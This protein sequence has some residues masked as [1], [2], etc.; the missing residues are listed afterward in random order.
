[1]GTRISNMAP[2]HL[3]SITLR[4]AYRM[5]QRI[6]NRVRQR[7][8]L[9]V[10]EDDGRPP[11]EPANLSDRN[12]HYPN[13]HIRPKLSSTPPHTDV[14]H[15][16]LAH[17]IKLRSTEPTN[18]LV[19]NSVRIEQ[20]IRDV[21]LAAQHEHLISPFTPLADGVAKDM[22]MRRVE[23]LDEQPHAG[24]LHGI[25]PRVKHGPPSSGT[26]R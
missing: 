24:R 1:M 23:D 3:C 16:H 18:R 21:L 6:H 5:S 14:P 4:R 19:R 8:I 10:I 22:D 26:L 12:P 2:A 25:L 7:R 13:K 17:Q 9:R 11:N 15:D 20:F